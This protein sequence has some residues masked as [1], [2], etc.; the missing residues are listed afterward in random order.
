M[1]AL[2]HYLD[3]EW[4]TEA[5]HHPQVLKWTRDYMSWLIRAGSP[6]G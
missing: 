3:V 6:L 1:T 4:L 5:F 2:N